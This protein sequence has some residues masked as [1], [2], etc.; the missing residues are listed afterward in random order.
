MAKE[1]NELLKKML[2]EE[3]EEMRWLLD[4]ENKKKGERK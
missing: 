4:D 1:I 3:K 2:K